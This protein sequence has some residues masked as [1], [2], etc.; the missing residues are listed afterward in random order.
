VL[1]IIYGVAT[2]IGADVG[3]LNCSSQSREFFCSAV[4]I[5]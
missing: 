2:L 1:L 3:G 5:A 4:T